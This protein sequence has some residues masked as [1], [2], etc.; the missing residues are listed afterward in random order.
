MFVFRCILKQILI[1]VLSESDGHDNN[2]YL[3][4]SEM[5]RK[6]LTETIASEKVTIDESNEDEIYKGIQG[7]DFFQNIKL[8]RTK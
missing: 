4:P 7:I 8:Y 6:E 5:A 1:F 3:T 2:N